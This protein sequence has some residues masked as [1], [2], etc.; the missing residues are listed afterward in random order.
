MLLDN[1]FEKKQHNNQDNDLIISVFF[2]SDNK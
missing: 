1:K 2:C